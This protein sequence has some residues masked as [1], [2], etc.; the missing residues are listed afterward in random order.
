MLKR[1]WK[2]EM[3]RSIFYFCIVAIFLLVSLTYVSTLEA[4]QYRVTDPLVGNTH[5]DI[6]TDFWE[7]WCARCND[8]A[9]FSISAEGFTLT[10]QFSYLGLPV[11]GWFIG[12]DF[13]VSIYLS[14]AYPTR[15]NFTFY[16][17]VDPNFNVNDYINHYGYFGGSGG[18]NLLANYWIEGGSYYFLFKKEGTSFK[19]YRGDQDGVDEN[20]LLVVDKDGEC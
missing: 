13:R 1:L 20:D 18:W 5:S 10:G 2:E 6:N 16:E 4:Y 19:I 17:Y 8:S 12:G 7:W 15:S 9:G 14:S 11:K 3:K